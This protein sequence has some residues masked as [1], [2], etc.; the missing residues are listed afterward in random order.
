MLT[1]ALTMQILPQSSAAVFNTTHSAP[2]HLKRFQSS[3]L[4]K[5][6]N[7]P[8]LYMYACMSAS[9]LQ[10]VLK[11]IICYVYPRLALMKPGEGWAELMDGSREGAWQGRAP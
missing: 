4:R 11:G 3:L 1:A 7:K 6:T 9:I 5:Q 2:G 10:G 8:Q